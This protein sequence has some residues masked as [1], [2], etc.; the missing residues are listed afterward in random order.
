MCL[1]Y[2][3]LVMCFTEMCFMQYTWPKGGRRGTTEWQVHEICSTGWSIV[4]LAKNKIIG[5]AHYLRPTT[6]TFSWTDI[7][8]LCSMTLF[9][10]KLSAMT[11]KGPFIEHCM[12]TLLF[13]WL[14]LWQLSYAF[15]ILKVLWLEEIWDMK[16]CKTNTVYKDV[17]QYWKCWCCVINVV[18]W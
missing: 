5:P 11:E 18:W 16:S 3:D 15:T 14:L 10:H 1:Y 17:C 6:T 7:W 9:L 12:Q 8:C 13:I 2:P 4:N